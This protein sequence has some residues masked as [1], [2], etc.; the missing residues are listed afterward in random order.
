[1][2]TFLPEYI[3]QDILF[4]YRYLQKLHSNDEWI[5]WVYNLRQPDRRYAL[6]FVESWSSLKIL[7][8]ISALLASSTTL[9]VAWAV[10][11]DDAQTAFTIAS[12]VLGAGSRTWSTHWRIGN[13]AN[14]ERQ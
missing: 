10:V 1:M 2:S 4:A 6:E 5:Q 3:K 8:A 14:T 12:F 11:K 13:T 7:L 9:G